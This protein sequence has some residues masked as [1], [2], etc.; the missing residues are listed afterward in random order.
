[1]EL[2][3]SPTSR[4]NKNENHENKTETGLFSS[5]NCRICLSQNSEKLINLCECKEGTKN[6]H[7][8]CLIQW[9]YEKYSTLESVSCEYCK[10]PFRIRILKKY[11]CE[12]NYSD[13][14]EYQIYRKGLKAAVVLFLVTILWPIATIYFTNHDNSIDFTSI[15][16][17]S[18]I[19]V[20]CAFAFFLLCLFKLFITISTHYQLLEKQAD[21]KELDYPNL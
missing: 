8:S 14:E 10:K 2:D 12:R 20:T 11:S 5:E 9:I 21:C 19:P 6:V 3:T 16:F 17:I 13:L 18:L 7:E 4:L 15:F 1:M